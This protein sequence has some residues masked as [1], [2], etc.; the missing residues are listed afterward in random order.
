MGDRRARRRRIE[1]DTRLLAKRLDSLQRTMQMRSGLDMDRNQIRPGLCK[2]SK[3]RI[4][5]RDHEMHVKEERR[6]RPQ[7]RDDRWT[8]GD[9]RHE[10]TVHDIHMHPIGASRG[11]CLN[12]LTELGEIS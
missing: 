8:D 9:V 7:G 4:A 2:T 12:L 3:K 11:N 5:G 1:H 6:M 10:M